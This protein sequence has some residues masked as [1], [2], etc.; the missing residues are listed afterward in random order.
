MTPSRP[1]DVRD[2]WPRKGVRGDLHF[3]S[4]RFD[5]PGCLLDAV[6]KQAGAAPGWADDADGVPFF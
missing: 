2:P 4:Q 1:G 6:G 3:E 5:M